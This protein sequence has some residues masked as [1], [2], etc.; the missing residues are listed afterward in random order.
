M[1]KELPGEWLSEAAENNDGTGMVL[2]SVRTDIDK[3]RRKGK[4]VYWVQVS[5]SY[6][7][8]ANGMPTAG[9]GEVLA[10]VTE[11]LAATFDRDPVAMLTVITTGDGL[12]QWD[13][14]TASLHIFQ[15][16]FN[17]ALEG[18]DALDLQ[19][20]AAMDPDWESYHQ[21]LDAIK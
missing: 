6:D 10:R 12:R 1:D 14:Y 16:K 2:V 8:L 18:L 11:E 15:R 7:A 4:H 17:E 19:F 21:A 9:A 13:F 5:L 20:E 3:M